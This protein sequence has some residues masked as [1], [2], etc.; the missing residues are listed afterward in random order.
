MSDCL[1]NFEGSVGRGEEDGR[2]YS[3]NMLIGEDRRDLD[4][5][6]IKLS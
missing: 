1:G 6:Q 2:Y 4:A 5:D 3:L